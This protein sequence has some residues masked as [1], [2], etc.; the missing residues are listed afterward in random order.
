[1][2]D[3]FAYNVQ[4]KAY[5]SNPTVS[6]LSGY[7]EDENVFLW[8]DFDNPTQ[9][10]IDVLRNV[11]HLDELAIE[12]CTHSRQIPKLESFAHYHFFIVQ[13]LTPSESHSSDLICHNSEL[14]GFLADRYLITHHTATIPAIQ[15]TKKRIKLGNS[16]LPQGTAYLT[17]EIL[18]QMIDM[19]LP[20]LEHLE[21]KIRSLTQ[22]LQSEPFSNQSSL[23]YMRLSTHILDL[24]RVASKNQQ[25]FYQFS[26]STMKFIDPDEARLFRDIHDHMIRVMDMSEYYQHTLHDALNIQLSLNSN[27]VN[28]VVQ[29][30]TI[31]ATIMLPLNVLTGIYGMNFS[32][33]PFL[34]SPFGFLLII[35]TMILIVLA[36]LCYF[37]HRRWI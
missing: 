4:Q 8:V 31:W 7:V 28:Q 24:R 27:R 22:L 19:Y 29:F 1:M 33:M 35:T 25:V 10:E 37:R 36:L 15:N 34:D 13:G 18:D 9:E 23:N 6:D 3:I 12:D 14:D 20:I 21:E 11:F 5:C 26:H 2:I 17:Y 32:W 30:L 16:R